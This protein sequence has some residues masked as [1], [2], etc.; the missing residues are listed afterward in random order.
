MKVKV[1]SLAREYWIYVLALVLMIAF[2]GVYSQQGKVLGEQAKNKTQEGI[3]IE[4][5]VAEKKSEAKNVELKVKPKVQS[6]KSV[7][8][9]K[10]AGEAD[11]SE[12]TPVAIAE[13]KY[14]TFSIDGAKYEI[15]INE[16]DDAFTVLMRAAS[17]KSFSVGYKTYSFGNMIT[18]IAGK[19]AEGTYYWALYYNDEYSMAGAG[20]LV[21][22]EGDNIEWRYESWM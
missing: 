5:E 4:P 16:G 15:K 7:V 10:P 21:V 17:T 18:E 6:P 19:K 8:E 3:A 11:V 9:E 2:L 12:E 1:V 14:V 22:K 13:S 20:E